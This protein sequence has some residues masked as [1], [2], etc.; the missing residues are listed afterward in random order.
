[1]AFPAVTS[2]RPDMSKMDGGRRRKMTGRG[3]EDSRNKMHCR[4]AFLR[5]IASPDAR[6][7]ALPRRDVCNGFG[8]TSV[9]LP[10][11]VCLSGARALDIRYSQVNTK[12][13]FIARIKIAPVKND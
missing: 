13:P 8:A 10:H 1:M 9:S 4:C 7:R 2:W 3:T 11:A 5:F 12:S 6:P